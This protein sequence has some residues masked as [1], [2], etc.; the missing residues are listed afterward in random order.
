MALLKLYSD[1][2]NELYQFSN[3]SAGDFASLGGTIDSVILMAENRIFRE[4]RCREMEQTITTSNTISG[5]VMTLPADYIDLKYAYLKNE[6]PN[7]FLLKRT[8]SWIRERYPFRS[9]SS[10]PVAIAREG[11]NFIFGPYPDTGQTYTVGGYYWGR[12]ATIIGTTATAS[13]NLVFATHPDLYLS[14]AIAETAPFLGMDARIAIWEGKYQSIKQALW[15]EVNT[16]GH[17]GSELSF[18]V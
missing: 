10:K 17:E 12:P 2:K 5:G 6:N 18:D 14:A 13:M 3:S 16:E 11:S 15:D 4:V 1:L 8:A 7:R 9:A